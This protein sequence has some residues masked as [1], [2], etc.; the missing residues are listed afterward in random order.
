MGQNPDFYCTPTSGVLELIYAARANYT[1]SLEFKAQESELMKKG[2]INFCREGMYGFYDAVT[3]KKYVLDKSRGW[4]IYY[5]FLNMIHPNP[6]VICMV[7][8][9]RDI[10]SSMEKK[11]RTNPDKANDMIDWSKMQGTTVPK[12]I[13]MWIQSPPI[14]VALERLSE[15]FRTGISNKILF[16]KYEDMC[17]YPDI[18]MKKIY[19]FLELEYYSHDFDNI[20][21]ITKEDDEV[22]GVYG[23]H[24][25]RKSIDLLPS[26]AS[27]ILGRDVTNWIYENYRWFFEEFRY[28]K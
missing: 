4:A 28:S 2:F 27:D 20:M 9:L 22:Y 25:I 11:F 8:D 18:T 21:Q 1:T 23:D 14:G 3:D 17:L 6:K 5:D 24:K 7:R 26:D 19:D 12:R 16:I 15:L 13:D 10:F